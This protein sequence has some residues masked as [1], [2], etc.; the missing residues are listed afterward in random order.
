MKDSVIIEGKEYISSRRASEMT[1]YSNDYVGQLCRMKKIQ[2][3]KIGRI[4]FIEKESLVA[5]QR[6]AEVII[7]SGPYIY[8]Q[9]VA[10]N[11]KKKILSTQKPVFSIAPSLPTTKYSPVNLMT[12]SE[13]ELASFPIVVPD[14]AWK[15]TN[16][17]SIPHSSSSGSRVRDSYDA[18]QKIK[19]RTYRIHPVFH[20][21]QAFATIVLALVFVAVGTY[22][23]TNPDHAFRSIASIQVYF[24]QPFI[25]SGKEFAGIFSNM[26]GKSMSASVI[27]VVNPLVGNILDDSRIGVISSVLRLMGTDISK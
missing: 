9:K 23:M 11:H 4:W 14:I 16:N 24:T 7:H 15:I 20:H 1:K 2:S 22:C 19:T 8:P 3:T 25:S 6:D 27:D 17:V 26:F 21:A 10:I 5:H 13:A 12:H 18:I